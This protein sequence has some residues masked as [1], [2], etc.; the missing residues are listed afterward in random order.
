MPA[1][2]ARAGSARAVLGQVG[3][4]GPC[5]TLRP[6]GNQAAGLLRAWETLRA[7]TRRLPFSR[8]DAHAIPAGF[9]GFDT[10]QPGGG[11]ATCALELCPAFACR[12]SRSVILEGRPLPAGRPLARR[13]AA[14]HDD[15]PDAEGGVEDDVRPDVCFPKSLRDKAPRRAASSSERSGWRSRSSG[16]PPASNAT[17]G[18]PSRAA[19]SGCGDGASSSSGRTGRRRRRGSLPH[20]QSEKR[21]GSSRT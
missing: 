3:P 18:M 4:G 16:S 7:P 9:A 19:S 10:G 13:L 5:R 14:S 6:S 1:G 15:V 20:R 21:V 12:A 8:A 17:S 2:M 11:G